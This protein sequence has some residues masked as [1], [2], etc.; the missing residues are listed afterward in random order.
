MHHFARLRPCPAG[1]R[2]MARFMPR[3]TARAQHGACRAHVTAFVTLHV[4]ME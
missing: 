3:R 2:D 1:H 4:T